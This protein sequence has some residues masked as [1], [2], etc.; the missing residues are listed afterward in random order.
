M[1]TLGNN[2]VLMGYISPILK[3]MRDYDGQKSTVWGN[4]NVQVSLRF[5]WFHTNK[6]NLIIDVFFQSKLDS[7][8]E[9]VSKFSSKAILSYMTVLGNT[10]ISYTDFSHASFT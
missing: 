4:F 3:K 6:I 9:G 2:S 7:G 8:T 1:N 5:L 10:S